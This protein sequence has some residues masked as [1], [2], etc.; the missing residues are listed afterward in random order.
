[1]LDHEKFA[2]PSAEWPLV[3]EELGRLTLWATITSVADLLLVL[4]PIAF[5]GKELPLSAIHGRIVPWQEMLT[6][7]ADE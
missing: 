4:A 1:M 6:R 3:P 2:S 5:I 7:S